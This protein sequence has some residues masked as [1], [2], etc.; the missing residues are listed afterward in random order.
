[1]HQS[2]FGLRW[3]NQFFLNDHAWTL[4]E[5]G[6][7]GVTKTIGP[8]LAGLEEGAATERAVGGLRNRHAIDKL[9]IGSTHGW[10]IFTCSNNGNGR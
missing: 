9:K 3:G 1:M 8:E 5:Y 4:N 2:S 7:L 10:S 6:A